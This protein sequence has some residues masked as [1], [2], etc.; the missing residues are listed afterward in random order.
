MTHFDVDQKKPAC[1]Q[2]AESN[3]KVYWVETEIF[4]TQILNYCLLFWNLLFILGNVKPKTDKNF[5][6]SMILCKY[7]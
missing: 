2:C 1:Q 3:D 7:I 6:L 5:S 4:E